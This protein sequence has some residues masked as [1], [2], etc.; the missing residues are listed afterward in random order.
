MGRDGKRGEGRETGRRREGR[1]EGEGEGGKDGG[2]EGRECQPL[3]HISG[4]AT[5]I[6]HYVFTMRLSEPTTKI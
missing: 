6:M 2:R 5:A 3:I 4:Y 1:R